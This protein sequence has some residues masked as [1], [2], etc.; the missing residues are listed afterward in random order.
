MVVNV[1]ERGRECYEGRAWE[2]AYAALACAD[3]TTALAVADL[4]RLATAA[5]LTGR[6]TEFQRSLERLHRVHVAAGAGAHAARCAFWLGLTLLFRGDVAQS[7]AWRER[8][9]RLIR[10][11]DC[12]ERGYLMV[13][14]A[15]QQLHQGQV[16]AGHATANEAASIGERFGD[17]DLT[18]AAVHL[19][20][21]ALIQRGEVVAGLQR[22]DD[23]M[24]A[25][26]AGELSP[27]MTG[28]LYCSVI[29]SCCEVYALGRAREWTS[30]F[31]T[32]CEQQPQ[33]IAF[34]GTCLVHRATILEFQGAWTA[35][36]SEAGRACQRAEQ[37]GRK[38]PGAAFYRQAEVYRLA[39]EFG[40]AEDAYHSASELGCEPHPGLAVAT[41]PN[42]RKTA[43][44]SC[45]CTR[46]W[47]TPSS[48]IRLPGSWLL[49][50]APRSSRTRAPSRCSTWR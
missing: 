50:D 46:Q 33:M 9:E 31:S 36:L 10:D 21:R 24:L 34:S 48:G 30:A 13:P 12:V 47:A 3:Q 22:L 6:D 5:Y 44:T 41:A 16:E 38:P 15:A 23:A 8:G 11:E 27:I 32:V 28:L 2:G 1:L 29:D 37:A 42:V 40:K 19:Q 18:A 45:G 43:R 25:V 26:V 4:E 17:G 35:A 39:G 49:L 7:H 14:V 20:G